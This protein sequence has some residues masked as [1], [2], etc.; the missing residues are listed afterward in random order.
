MEKATLAPGFTKCRSHNKKRFHVKKKKAFLAFFFYIFMLY[1]LIAVLL[2]FTRR[3]KIE[4]NKTWRKV[5]AVIIAKQLF[6]FLSLFYCCFV[7]AT[8]CFFYFFFPGSLNM[9]VCASLCLRHRAKVK[10]KENTSKRKTYTTEISSVRLA[11]WY[12]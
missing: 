9:L 10:L 5:N 3:I 11:N 2:F 7:A 4:K 12:P 1:R 8:S 6:F